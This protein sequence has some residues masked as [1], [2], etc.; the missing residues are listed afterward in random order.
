MWKLAAMAGLIA[1]AAVAVPAAAQAPTVTSKDIAK[2]AVRNVA[3]ARGTISLNRLTKSTQALILKAGTP[4]PTGATGATG[5]QG[6]TGPAGAR[7]AQGATG[8]QGARGLQGPQGI[9][10]PQGRPG[11][12]GYE[13]V[14]ADSATVANQ[15][16][17]SVA[18]PAGKR[19]IGGGGVTVPAGGAVIASLPDPT[20][21]SWSVTA[22]RPAGAANW[23]LTIRA[24]CVS[25]T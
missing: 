19:V 16:T 14:A 20:G 5:P 17:N 2:G 13:I 18:C 3:I 25:V 4:G 15:V 8:A 22:N 11:V 21:T 10:G 23:S 6:P 9:Q 1:A 12:S 7:G 24:V